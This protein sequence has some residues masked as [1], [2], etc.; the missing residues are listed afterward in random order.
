MCKLQC[1]TL[2]KIPHLANKLFNNKCVLRDIR[3]DI[4]LLHISS[5]MIFCSP[6][7]FSPVK[8]AKIRIFIFLSL[9]LYDLLKK[10]GFWLAFSFSLLSS[11]SKDS[12]GLRYR[13]V[14][15]AI[16]VLV[17]TRA[18]F[19]ATV[20]NKRDNMR[21]SVTAKFVDSFRCRSQFRDIRR[22]S[23]RVLVWQRKGRDDIS[24]LRV[25]FAASYYA[26]RFTYPIN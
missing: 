5:A 26:A 13:H 4:S 22:L 21:K 7:L 12:L 6:L 24:M 15:D 3:N 8:N 23:I 2:S 17:D 16:G 14:H 19:D 9:S 1:P 11:S 25:S 10:I 20:D 18:A